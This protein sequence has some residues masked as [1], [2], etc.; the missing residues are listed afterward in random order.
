[1]TRKRSFNIHAGLACLFAIALVGCGSDAPSAQEEKNFK[2]HPKDL[3][4]PTAEQMK[5]SMGGPSHIGPADGGDGKPPPA[6]VPTT[7]PK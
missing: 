5:A 1:M 7:A 2:D 4:P 3:K 6:G